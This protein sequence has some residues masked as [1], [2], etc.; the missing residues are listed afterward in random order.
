MN[1]ELDTILSDETLDNTAKATKINELIGNKY[2]PT[3]KYAETKNNANAQYAALKQEY[4]DF[5][6][7]KMTDEEKLEAEKQ[8]QITKLAEANKKISRLSVEKI[9]EGKGLPENEYSS[10]VDDLSSLGTDKAVEL[11]ERI[12]TML[13]TQKQNATQAYKTQ[14]MKNQPEP[15]GGEPA[16]KE[17][18]DELL[19][20]Q[21]KLAE[22][23]EKGRGAEAAHYLKEYQELLKKNGG[24]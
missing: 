3:Q 5:K 24:N 20:I 17:P 23:R 4:E 18:D 8:E 19:A 10:F 13:T 21:T 9:F 7:S 15:K 2:V 22:A 6:K 12:C 14:L 16:S 11:A 1:E